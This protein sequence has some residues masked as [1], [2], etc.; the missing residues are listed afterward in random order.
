MMMPDT[1]TPKPYMLCW[2]AQVLLQVRLL[3]VQSGVVKKPSDP[4]SC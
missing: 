1:S 2:C 4:S 3:L